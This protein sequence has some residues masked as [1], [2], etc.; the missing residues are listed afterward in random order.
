MHRIIL[1]LCITVVLGVACDPVEENPSN[2]QNNTNNT[3]N[4]NNTNN[5]NNQNNTNNTNNTQPGT[6]NVE[7]L[8][9]QLLCTPGYKCTLTNTQNTV[10]CVRDN[11]PLDVGNV[12]VPVSPGTTQDGCPG[13]SYCQKI[14]GQDIGIC[15]LFCPYPY[16]PCNEQQL[17]LDRI[18]TNM[19]TAWLC[20]DMDSCDP[21]W[22]SG[23]SGGKSCYVY[24]SAN[25]MTK[26]MTPGTKYKNEPCQSSEEC[27]PSHTCYENTCRFLC[28]NHDYCGIDSCLY[29]S[30]HDPYGLCM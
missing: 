24:I 25:N 30:A 14:P 22:D 18:S 21:F 15:T 5:T 20:T 11:G 27:L 8:S 28:E 4:Q 3:N 9:F 12:C 13:G 19:G 7:D 6:C 17:C 2:N 1:V 26:C 10:G 29:L 16:T 23:C